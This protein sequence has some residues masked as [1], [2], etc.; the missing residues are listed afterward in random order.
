MPT[1]ISKKREIRPI[2]KQDFDTSIRPQDDFYRYVNGGWL[3]RN[4]IPPT[5]SRWGSFLI[6]RDENRKNLHNILKE[7]TEKKTPKKGSDV[8][9][10]KDLYLSSMDMHRRNRQKLT[11][12]E[13]S[14]ARIDNLSGRDAYT[15]LFAYLHLRSIDAPFALWFDQDDKNSERMVLRI[16][17]GG[18]GVPDRDYYIKKDKESKRILEAYKKYLY[19]M[20]RLEGFYKKKEVPKVVATILRIEKK[21]AIASMAKVDR[22]DPHKTY[23]KRTVI[24]L[25]KDYPYMNWKEYFDLLGV[26]KK[27]R[28]HIIVD[29]PKFLEEVNKLLR[30]TSISDWKK[31]LRWH[32]LDEY[33]GTLGEDFLAV[34]FTYYG[35]AIQG[36]VKMPELWKRSVGVT[37][38]VLPDTLGKLYIKKYFPES[39]KKKISILVK[40]LI[41]AYR[42]RLK[43]LDWMSESTKKKALRKLDT[44]SL[45]LGY[46]KKWQSYRALRIESESFA[47]NIIQ[48]AIFHFGLE[49]KKL[50]KPTDKNEWYMSAPTVN[51]YYSPNLNQ[52]VFPAG[53]LQPPFFYPNADNAVNYG[54]IGAVIGHEMTHAFDDSGA[55]FDEYGNLRNWW[56][57]ADIKR[58]KARTKVLVGQFNRYEIVDGIKLNGK[59]TLG[60]NIADL[61]GAIIAFKALRMSQRNKISK[62]IDGFTPSQRFFIS[63]ALSE[64]TL[65]RD[66]FLKFAALNDPHSPNEFRSNGPMSNMDE[67]YE[68]FG[69][70]RGDALYRAPKERVRIW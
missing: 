13:E 58:F 19:G 25:Q 64:R 22:R 66:K 60:E 26:P 42:L 70:K 9:K 59:F 61:G 62:N 47:Q 21:L 23:N 28:Q 51:A 27:A 57:K 38:S 43:E 68:T 34:Q 11:Y 40:N 30:T 52:I 2:N 41:K 10:L 1:K 56:S 63:H 17:Q 36:L 7:L 5:E 54:A 67:F 37:N 12:L 45:Q 65:I 8:E 15:S 44:M 18:I 35:K 4:T 32:F 46:P 55:K 33:A 48:A 39:S 6:L 29:Q 16:G 53:I 69:V 31:Y 24:E 20:L 14:F 3:K 49:V 50:A